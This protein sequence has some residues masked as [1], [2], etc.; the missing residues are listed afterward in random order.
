MGL[1]NKLLTLLFGLLFRPFQS[2]DPIWAL[3]FISLV[4]GVLMLWLF[5][6][7]SNQETIRAVRDRIRGNLLGVRLFGDDP[8]L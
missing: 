4:A 8:A 6:K 2:F 3:I 1:F 5:G 7:V